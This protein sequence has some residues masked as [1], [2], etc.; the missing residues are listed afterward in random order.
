MNNIDVMK[1]ALE[2]LEVAT[3]PLAKDR[4]EVLRAQAALRTAIEA[5][6]SQQPVAWMY[7]K[8]KYPPN[9]LRGQQWAPALWFLEPY[10][11]N[12]MTKN[13]RPLYTTPP[14]PT[15]DPLHLS[16]ILHELAGAASMCWTP[17]PTGVFDSQEAIKHVVAAI[18][19]IRARSNT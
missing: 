5:A 18:E 7:D 4:Q 1:Q 17:A 9:D 2:A 13:V 10:T 15:P 3:T 12:G 19:E 8:A 14:A 11:G 6:E 16:R